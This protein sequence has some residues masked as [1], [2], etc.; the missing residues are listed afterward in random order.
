MRRRVIG[1]VRGRTARASV[2]SLLRLACAWPV[3]MAARGARGVWPWLSSR[4]RIPG[5]GRLRRG[6]DRRPNVPRAERSLQR[7][8]RP[9]RRSLD[10]PDATL[11]ANLRGS[12][13]AR[14]TRS[15]TAPGSTPITRTRRC[16]FLQVCR[17]LPGRREAALRLLA[18][19]IARR[20][21]AHGRRAPRARRT[22]V[23]IPAG[24][25]DRRG[26]R[27]AARSRRRPP[28]GRRVAGCR[29]GCA[30]VV[31]DR[32]AQR[33]RAVLPAAIAA[34]LAVPAIGVLPALW[35]TA[36]RAAGIAT[37]VLLIVA[38]TVGPLVSASFLDSC[39]PSRNR[40]N[41]RQRARELRDRWTRSR[42]RRGC[43]CAR[44]VVRAGSGLQLVARYDDRHRVRDVVVAGLMLAPVLWSQHLALLLIPLTVLFTRTL[45]DGSSLGLAS[46]AASRWSSRC[47][48]R[49]RSASRS[50]LPHSR[51]SG[52]LAP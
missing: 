41:L 17:C 2:E 49:S 43:S 48:T 42:D 7:G 22:F 44:R 3:L 16:C 37:G 33:D 11:S 28:G 20:H 13:P 9:C 8:S 10:D 1:A 32:P 12:R 39:R 52:S 29:S 51:C 50:C 6:G 45:R 30:R 31:P 25:H 35:R 46:L 5:S 24:A 4:S 36:P 15:R 18:C 27:L 21:R 34:C 23:A 40:A 26:R 38:A 14:G 47:P 19:R